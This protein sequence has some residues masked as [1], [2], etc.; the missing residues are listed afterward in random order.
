MHKVNTRKLGHKYPP[1]LRLGYV[2]VII[3]H[4]SVRCDYSSMSDAND[5]LAKSTLKS[6]HGWVMELIF[7]APILIDLCW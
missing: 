6:R 2:Y 5:G 7:N 1:A 4:K 3:S